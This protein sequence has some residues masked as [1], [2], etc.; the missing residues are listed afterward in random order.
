MAQFCFVVSPEGN[1]LDCYRTWEALYLGCIPVVKSNSLNQLY[2]NLPVV[3]VDDWHQV[4]REFLQEQ[5]DVIKN[6]KYEQE[7]LSIYYWFGR[8]NEY[9]YPPKNS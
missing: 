1:G 6:K 8:I 7:K 3:I 2:E 5:L 9:K 4:T